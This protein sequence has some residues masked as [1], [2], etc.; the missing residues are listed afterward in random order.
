VG[1]GYLNDSIG[2]E[3]STAPSSALSIEGGD[4]WTWIFSRCSLHCTST[5]SSCSP[6]T[7]AGKALGDGFRHIPLQD[8]ELT[9]NT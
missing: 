5:S 9:E 4:P 7:Q 3:V 2:W 8:L 1:G 6:A